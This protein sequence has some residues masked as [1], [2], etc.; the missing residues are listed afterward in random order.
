MFKVRHFGTEWAM[1]KQS[2]KRSTLGRLKCLCQVKSC[3]CVCVCS[4]CVIYTVISC[5]ELKNSKHSYFM[6]NLLAAAGSDVTWAERW[7]THHRNGCCW[8]GQEL[9]CDHMPSARPKIPSNWLGIQ[10]SKAASLPHFIRKEKE[11]SE[12]T[13]IPRILIIQLCLNN[14]LHYSVHGNCK[15]QWFC[16]S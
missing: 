6:L 9:T 10:L 2:C 13:L 11:L 4:P 16:L 8:H 7:V 14:V 15:I 3:A 12:W 1:V 5:L